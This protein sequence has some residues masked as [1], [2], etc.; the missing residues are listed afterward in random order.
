MSIVTAKISEVKIGP[1]TMQGLMSDQGEFGVAVPQIAKHFQFPNKH[2]SRDLKALCGEG[3]QFP[4]WATPLNPK[5]VNVLPLVAVEKVILELALKGHPLAVEMTRALVGLSLHQL[6]C[7]SF[8]V[9]FGPAQRQEFLGDRLKRVSAFYGWTDC[10]KDY[11]QRQGIYGTDQGNRMFGDCIRLVNRRLFDQPHFNC[12]RDTMTI[13]QQLDIETFET[14]LKR[15]YKPG[16]NVT[17][18][19]YK[20][21]DF[22]QNVEH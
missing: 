18:V 13:E 17:D 19:I 20:C 3:F 6:F 15:H 4:K 7:D 16:A 5:A 8:G 11:Q 9:E 14:L 2:A 12:D 21:L 10:I 1:L 22:F